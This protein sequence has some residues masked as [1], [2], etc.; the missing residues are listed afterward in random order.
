[1]DLVTVFV[2]YVFLDERRVSDELW[3]RSLSDCTWYAQTLHKQSKT[4]I[5]SYCLPK[6]VREQ[7]ARIY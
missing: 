5:T 2:L 6:Q 1:M 7:G 3:F 4:R